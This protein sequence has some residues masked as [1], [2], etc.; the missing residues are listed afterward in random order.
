MTNGIRGTRDYNPQG[1]FEG[2]PPPLQCEIED[3]KYNF[4][5]DSRGEKVPSYGL[6]CACGSFSIGRTMV[7]PNAGVEACFSTCSKKEIGI[8]CNDRN[9]SMISPAIISCC[10]SCGGS[11]GYIS[12]LYYSNGDPVPSRRYGCSTA[13]PS[14][15]SPTPSPTPFV[16]ELRIDTTKRPKENTKA[17]GENIKLEVEKELGQD[18]NVKTKVGKYKSGSSLRTVSTSKDR[19]APQDNSLVDVTISRPMRN[20]LPNRNCA[21]RVVVTSRS[22]IKEEIIR[23]A[24]TKLRSKPG[25]DQVF[26]RS[27]A[28]IKRKLAGRQYVVIIVFNNSYL[29][30]F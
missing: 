8:E 25:F 5:S 11:A 16:E 12:N 20:C 26:D 7:I 30:L 9:T 14:T 22:T 15:R 29:R 6:M 2:T 27:R 17:A 18:V 28:F 10:T 1:C 23:R 3:R 21:A 24:Y 13:S 4:Y 19:K